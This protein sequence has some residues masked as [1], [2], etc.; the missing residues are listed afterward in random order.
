MT[1]IASNEAPQIVNVQP[2]VYRQQSYFLQLIVAVVILS[3]VGMLMVPLIVHNRQA[4][5]QEASK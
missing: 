2:E 4:Q 3:V 5:T 1:P